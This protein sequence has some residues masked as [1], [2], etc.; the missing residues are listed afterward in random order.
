MFAWGPITVEG[1]TRAGE[2]FINA[3]MRFVDGEYFR[4]MRI[5]LVDGRLFTDD[6][7]RPGTLVALVDT[8]M[9][10]QL[11]PGASPLGRRVQLGF[12]DDLRRP[13]SPSSASSGGSSRTPSTASRASRCITRPRPVPGRGP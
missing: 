12:G 11:W 9:A 2:A 13:G 1:R 5:P 6:D 4:A 7:K 8:H 3:D 10:A